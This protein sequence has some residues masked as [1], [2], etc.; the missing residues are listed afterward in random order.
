MA[1]IAD[2]LKQVSLLKGILPRSLLGR[3]VM[4]IVTP[5]ILLQLVTTSVFY[6][7]H[8]DTVT[9]RL[10]RGV[11]GDIATI[12][13]MMEQNRTS[14]A[15]PKLFETAQQNMQLRMAFDPGAQLP[16]VS[17]PLRQ[18]LVDRNL[19]TALAELVKRPFLID[20]RSLETEVE[21]HVQ[22]DSGVLQIV[23]PRRRLFSSTTYVVI[24][25]MVGTSLALFTVAAL[26]MRS[27]VRPIRR[28][29]AA[30]EAFG[31]GRDS[32]EFTVEGASEVRQ[33]ATAF[34]VMRDRIR[35]QITQRTDMLAGVSHDLRTP[36]TRMKLAL[37]M[38]GSGQEISDLKA[39]VAAME[40]MVGG[41]LTFARGEGREAMSNID[42]GEL[43][44][45]VAADARRE[46]ASITLE[47]GSDL[48][49]TVRPEAMQRAFANL[50]GNAQR[51][52]QNIRVSGLRHADAIEIVIDDDGPGVPAE[53]RE[54]VFR[55]FY[56]LEESRNPETGGIGLGLTIARDIVRSHGGDVILA[57][58]PMGGLR[59]VLRL[60]V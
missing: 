43:L 15:W 20:T 16:D 38:M 3:S 2:R 29:A 21:I 14:T 4:I 44:Q 27:Q 26:F 11:A 50:I 40:K 36:L 13:E 55:P 47:N 45:D 39:D 42:L 52:A 7:S 25:W 51:Y 8:W 12:I 6:D 31:K 59:A 9:K 35:R 37:A 58:S 41:Y 32:D 23:A 5:L 18:T 49:A 10:A 34:T 54:E 57:D 28:L 30:A 48:A 17:S 19:G 1:V 60:P 22:M 53:K 24:L 56:R 46:G 33:A